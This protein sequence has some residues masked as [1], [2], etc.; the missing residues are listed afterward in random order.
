VQ[1]LHPAAISFAQIE[2]QEQSNEHHQLQNTVSTIVNNSHFD[3][4]HP[5]A[6]G[7]KIFMKAKWFEFIEQMRST[8]SSHTTFIRELY[9]W[10]VVRTQDIIG[11]YKLLCETDF[12]Q[13]D[14]VW[15]TA[16]VLVA[17]NRERYS[18]TPI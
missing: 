3:D 15:L 12:S 18:L 4:S 6:I 13:P 7:T 9:A 5:F 16:P 1:A 17:T 14:S 8:D 2:Y 10:H 11:K